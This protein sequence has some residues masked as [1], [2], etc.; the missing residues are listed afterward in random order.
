MAND[1][2]ADH[3]VSISSCE[4]VGSHGSS[5]SSLVS[6]TSL[7]S[8]TDRGLNA[9]ICNKSSVD[10]VAEGAPPD[11]VEHSSTCTLVKEASISSEELVDCEVE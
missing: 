11:G 3:S 5:G 10:I 7:S 8:G 4:V 2:L 9:S 1:G 6:S